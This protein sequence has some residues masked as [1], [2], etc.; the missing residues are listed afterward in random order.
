MQNKL[1][2]A[3]IGYGKMGKIRKNVAE[4]NPMLELVGVCEIS[5]AFGIG[6]P[7]YKNY[8]DIIKLD[9]D[10]VFVCTPNLFLSEI[11]CFFLENKVHVFCEK[12]P[13]RNKND[14]KKMLDVDI[15]PKIKLKFGFNHRYH[16]AVIDAK[17]I[18]DKKRFGKILWMRGIYGKAGGNG[19]DKEWRNK[20]LISG[21]GIL[22]DQGIHMV[23][24]FRHFCGD[25]NEIKSF[26]N[27]SFWN[28]E[29]EDN[30]FALLRNAVGQVAM[31]HSSATQW[32]HTFLLDIYLEKGYL[33]ISG[34]L[35]STNT[36]SPETLKIARCLY[37]NDGYN[38]A[39][40]DEIINYYEND[41]SWELEINE[42]I[43][44]IINDEPVSVGTCSDAY[45]TMKLIEN[46]YSDDMR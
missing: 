23:D 9:P 1:K 22:L 10:I 32:K 42:F 40:P 3:I 21:G 43:S 6:V 27:H 35:S 20:K 5:D 46:I 31:L 28:T 39:N 24:L 13:G 41:Q 38:M 15:D 37:D 17:S 2:I 45:Q 8:K 29:V 33:S 4:R 34:I 30:A 14:V 12:P 7:V 19:F 18:I 25:F 26:I 44:S 11:V 16:Q 36:Y